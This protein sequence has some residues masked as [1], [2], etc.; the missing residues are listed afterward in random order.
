MIQFLQLNTED[1]KLLIEQVAR[2]TGLPVQ[3]IEKDW[4]VT[5]VLR[6]LF[7]LPM[8]EYFIF[9][10]GTSLS[11][12]W[13]LIERFSEDIDIALSPEAFGRAYVSE[14][15]HSYVKTLKREGCAYTTE[16]IKTALVDQLSSMGVP[17]NLV[18]IEAEAVS[19][20]KPDKD[21][22]TLYVR[23]TS[24]FSQTGYLLDTIKLEFGVRSL[25][26]PYSSANV[27]S[28]LGKEVRSVAYAENAFTVSAVEPRK[29]FMEKMMLL[30]EKYLQGI[31]P[32][33]AE[34][35]SR[36]LYDLHSMIHSKV[37]DEVLNDR[38]LYQTLLKH[39]S[40]YVRLKGINYDKMFL[41]ALRF[42]P[43]EDLLAFFKTDYE[44]MIMHMTY[45]NV[46]DF[47]TLVQGL[48]AF[49]ARVD[50]HPHE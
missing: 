23:Y 32:R 38:A 17:D 18:S 40:H 41:H 2:K 5:F 6:A 9:K 4:W 11:K 30:H 39:R 20:T 21:P 8:A 49:K 1:R 19:P 13:N 3:S 37:A 31:Q 7:S 36:H 35:Q 25:L 46:P 27:I 50:Q 48:I 15:S 14:P 34:R 29:T 45:G 24:L 10:G 22:Q 33:S 28:I 43:P 16:I 26:E 42:I 47:E 12:A 44:N